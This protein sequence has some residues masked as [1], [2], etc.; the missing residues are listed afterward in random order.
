MNIK[1]KNVAIIFAG[2][3][4]SRM[5]NS[6]TPKQ[7]LEYNDKPIIIYTIEHFENHENIDEIVVVCIESWIDTLKDYCVKY[8]IKKV[9]SIVKGGSTGHD[10]IWNGIQEVHRV[11]KNYDTNVLIHDGVRPLID[12]K[13][14]D[15]NLIDLR[16]YGSSITAIPAYETI[17]LTDSNLKVD[18]TIDRHGCTLLR[19]PQCFKLT[20]IYNA[21]VKAQ[22]EQYFDAVD[23]ATLMEYFGHEIHVTLGLS[24]NI[25]ITTPIDFELFKAIKEQ[26]YD[27]NGI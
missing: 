13:Q 17:A 21:H 27:K 3:V 26:E 11:Y 18:K 19:A 10:S 12:R 5:G 1:E 2:G 16:K 14:I 20:D 15:N 22:N 4:G 6:E 8:N 23:S 7:F 24:S 25:K 9:N